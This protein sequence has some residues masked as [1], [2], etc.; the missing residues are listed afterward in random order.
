MISPAGKD[1]PISLYSSPA[2]DFL[3][4]STVIGDINLFNIPKLFANANKGLFKKSSGKAKPE[5]FG[6]FGVEKFVPAHLVTR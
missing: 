4:V 6:K 5:K 3:M 1:P 2:D